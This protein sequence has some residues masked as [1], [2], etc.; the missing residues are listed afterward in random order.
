M[1]STDRGRWVSQRKYLWWPSVGFQCFSD[2]MH[3]ALRMPLSITLITPFAVSLI[4]IFF[5]LNQERTRVRPLLLRCKVGV[6]PQLT[7]KAL[8]L[9]QGEQGQ[10]WV[11]LINN[12]SHGKSLHLLKVLSPLKVVCG[13]E[14]SGLLWFMLWSWLGHLLLLWMWAKGGQVKVVLW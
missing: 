11:G 8:I 1:S 10:K 5:S 4:L 2:K 6:T 12:L 3:C 9:H 7:W 14:N 13:G